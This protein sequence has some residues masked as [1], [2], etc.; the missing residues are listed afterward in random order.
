MRVNFYPDAVASPL[1]SSK[2]CCTR[3]KKG[4]EHC[5]PDKTEHSNDDQ[6]DK[7]PRDKEDKMSPEFL[8]K[9][10][11]DIKFQQVQNVLDGKNKSWILAAVCVVRA[12]FQKKT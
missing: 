6:H 8:E 3:T 2:A 7:I 4:I 11:E 1:R 10:K 12:W 5:V 9:V